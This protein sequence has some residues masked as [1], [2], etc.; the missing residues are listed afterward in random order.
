M[1]CDCIYYNLFNHKKKMRYLLI[2]LLI[3][4]F[5]I[6]AQVF[7][8]KDPF[9]FFSMD[10]TELDS[11][12]TGN[13]LTLFSDAAFSTEQ[14]A[15]GSHSIKFN[16]TDDRASIPKVDLGTSFT[17]SF[18]MYTS[19]TTDFSDYI[20]S[21]ASD[22]AVIF[23][24]IYQYS[25]TVVRVSVNDG[26]LRIISPGLFTSGA[27]NHFVI[28]MREYDGAC[29]IWVNGS[30]TNTADTILATG[31]DIP[32]ND[33]IV[34]GCSAGKINEFFGYI[35]ELRIYKGN[36]PSEAQVDSLFEKKY[37]EG[38][39]GYA[40]TLVPR[41]N[42]VDYKATYDG[43]TRYMTYGE[44]TQDN[45]IH[46]LF[47]ENFEN[48]DLGS[49]VID[50]VLNRWQGIVPN[51]NIPNQSIINTGLR[52]NVWRTIFLDGQG[53]S[54][55]GL[56]FEGALSQTYEELYMQIDV[57]VGTSWYDGLEDDNH[58][59]GK[60]PYGGFMGGYHLGNP[61]NSPFKVDTVATSPYSNGWTCHNGWGSGNPNNLVM[62]SY[63]QLAKNYQD[64]FGSI[65]RGEWHTYTTRVKLRTPGKATDII[66]KYVDGELTAQDTTMFFR[67]LQQAQAG[68]NSIEMW[69]FKYTFGGDDTFLSQGDNLFYLDN[70]VI[71]YYE[72]HSPHF[73]SGKAP[74]GHQ[75]PIVPIEETIYQPRILFDETFTA[76]TD[77]IK[78]HYTGGLIPPSSQRTFTKTITGQPNPFKLEFLKW[79]DGNNGVEGTT[80]TAT[81]SD[82]WVKI[83]A[84]NGTTLLK[85]YQE[86]GEHDGVPIVGYD[87]TIPY[88]GCVI[89]YF[90]GKDV[91]FGWTIRYW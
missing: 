63:D 32:S 17:F 50:T 53:G 4:C 64:L 68:M 83:Y 51:F 48:W 20:I 86:P 14:V 25:Q 5:N 62:Y 47:A 57:Y 34:I 49:I 45:D 36:F 23:Y 22:N 15:V 90:T 6:Q 28:S 41:Y 11:M 37:I 3:F 71:F 1:D 27:W 81:K 46:I 58:A 8:T 91:N 21:G 18:W 82:S 13:D 19:T 24:R 67:S 74:E 87:Y 56:E 39:R 52:G 65:K 40:P 66:E 78:S 72:P 55:P 42:A 73:L 29:K 88:N 12:L 85:W 10:N 43:L 75:I 59:S 26:T 54:S 61:N 7:S 38:E 76:S 33:S 44:N 70:I 2:I 60:A 84:P 31:I 35:D 69:V 89:K 80:T 77:T 79:H 30:L 16:G 9:L